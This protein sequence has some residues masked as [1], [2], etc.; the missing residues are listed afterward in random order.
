MK[1]LESSKARS[2]AGNESSGFKSTSRIVR[3]KIYRDF[4]QPSSAIIFQTQKNSMIQQFREAPS[5]YIFFV[6][7]LIQY[8]IEIRKAAGILNRIFNNLKNYYWGPD[9]NSGTNSP[10]TKPVQ[11]MDVDIENEH[12]A[13]FFYNILKD[14]AIYKIMKCAQQ[15]LED[16]KTTLQEYRI[17]I[18]TIEM[19]K[20]IYS[21]CKQCYNKALI[22]QRFNK[23]KG[24][25][26][27]QN[28]G[29]GMCNDKNCKVHH[30]STQ[31]VENQPVQNQEEHTSKLMN[32][33]QNLGNTAATI[34]RANATAEEIVA[35][36]DEDDD[37][38]D[39]DEDE[40]SSEDEIEEKYLDTDDIGA[41]LTEYKRLMDETL[42]T[43][44]NNEMLSKQMNDLSVE[45]V[46]N[47]IESKPENCHDSQG[48]KKKK[49]KKKKKQQIE[50]FEEHIQSKQ[51]YI[52]I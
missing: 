52:T 45:E 32:S 15:T 17:F 28:R 37:E 27:G 12:M 14:N 9:S 5:A 35:D 16:D 24:D 49:S 4:R 20:W 7:E 30:P 46:V 21:H 11:R 41:E 40:E 26:N 48:K 19:Y 42:S 23:H 2:I 44:R 3:I 31:T 43:I 51:L 1:S 8:F 36:E 34:T 18:R 13:L 6:H 39:D 25:A 47:M 29:Q 38:L 33:N 50:K 10:D 22:R